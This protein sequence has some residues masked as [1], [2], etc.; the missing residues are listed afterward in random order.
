ML[1]SVWSTPELGGIL[2]SYATM[3]GK[4]MF[5]ALCTRPDIAYTVNHLAQFTSCFGLAHITAIKR[6]LRY[7]KGTSFISLTYR[8]ANEDFGEVGYSD[9]D[10]GASPLDRKS[11]SGHIFMLRGAAVSWSLEKQPTV[12][13]STMEAEYMALMHTCMQDL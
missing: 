8:C 12:A 10:W 11:I 2:L 1:R 7:L 13:L 3:I 9:L 5:A 6:V 4:L